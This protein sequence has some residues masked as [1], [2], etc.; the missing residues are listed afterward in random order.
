MVTSSTR[1]SVGVNIWARSTTAVATEIT[2]LLQEVVNIRN[3]SMDYMYENFEIFEKGFRTWLTGRHLK[4]AILEIYEPGSNRL[5]E[6]YDL[7]LDYDYGHGDHERF[8]TNIEKFKNALGSRKLDSSLRYRVVVSLKED[9]PQLPG[10]SSTTLRD[11]GHLRHS[12]L[13]NVIDTARIGV[14]VEFWM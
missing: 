14:D 5:V 8:E 12:N 6:R 7:V 4:S 1:V 9:A 2:R 3:L 13:G 10:W 11:T